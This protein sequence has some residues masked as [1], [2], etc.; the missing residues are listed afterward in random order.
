LT[1]L[2]A[3]RYSLPFMETN[4]EHGSVRLAR[5]LLLVQLVVSPII[6]S[7]TTLEAFE[8]NKVGLLVLT[9]LLLATGTV[10]A[11]LGPT[12]RSRLAAAWHDVRRCPLSLSVIAF[13]LSTMLSTVAS[14]SPR[15]SVFGAH[16]SFSGLVMISAYAILFFA[17]RALFR[18]ANAA[19]WLLAAPV[20]GAAFSGGY[21]ALQ[22]AHLDPIH[23]AGVSP[24]AG[25]VRP[26][27]GLG[28]P[29]QLAAY[30]A[31]VLPLVV[32]FAWRAVQGRQSRALT[33]IVGIGALMAFAVL[34]AVSRG[35]WL[36]LIGAGA[37]TL[38]PWLHGRRL[39][40]K[41]GV[42]LLAI[43]GVVAW[44]TFT[45]TGQ[46]LFNSVVERG[47]HFGD[48]S[49]RAQIWRA[50]LG[51][52]WEHPV[53][54]CGLDTFNL[55]FQAQRTPK[56][57]H[58]EWNGTPTKAHSDALQVLATQGLV[59]IA[60][61]VAFTVALLRAGR[62]AW[63]SAT[64]QT[65]PLIA[66][67][68]G[69]C[70]AL[71]LQ[72]LFS[73]TTAATGVV[74]VTV[75]ALLSRLAEEDTREAAEGCPA[76]ALPAGSGLALLLFANEA[77]VYSGI[78]AARVL[79]GVG[80]LCIGLFAACWALTSLTHGTPEQRPAPAPGPGSRFRLAAQAGVWTA[81]LTA[82]VFLVVLPDLASRYVRRSDEW[83]AA[84]PGRAVEEL[85][86]ALDLDPGRD[87][88]WS[89]L[90]TAYQAK[91]VR[92]SND[93]L[94]FED[95]RRARAALD[96]A[97][98]L[99]PIQGYHYANR[100]RL[101]AEMVPLH[102]ATTD[103]TFADFDRALQFDGANA[104]FYLYAGHVART[105]GDRDHAHCYIGR[106]LQLYPRFGPLRTQD[107]FLA[108]SEGR[109][110]DAEAMYPE[111]PYLDW[112][113]DGRAYLNLLAVM[114]WGRL[115]HDCYLDA[116]V[117]SRHVLQHLPK[118]GLPRFTVAQALEGLG[119]KAEALEEYRQL[120]LV[121]PDYAPARDAR[122]RLEREL[123]VSAN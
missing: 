15:T 13:W 54:G 38:W 56:Y 107:A 3:R 48:A 85:G 9:S 55:A 45:T 93:E 70:A 4:R 112:H 99:V 83:L 28:H 52:W 113:D 121:C 119:R 57:W 98:A 61:A 104:Y 74:F 11:C 68:L 96:C 109:S 26:F 47:R 59:G 16:E 120:L 14:C 86:K 36:A 62:R 84:D 49:S 65:R 66:A 5:A 87:L 33:V 41:A 35:A 50:A 118:W 80:A 117:V 20:V 40:V 106:G 95:L 51:I 100:G 116:L 122:C 1:G 114:A 69:V 21:A 82:I 10:A 78:P 30:L 32:Y 110:D 25:Y 94:Q 23:W 89:R 8:C 2:A 79:V 60:A 18:S 91:A 42:A 24:L 44:V 76:W 43:I 22:V 64:A 105:L 81:G 72:G 111:A 77:I 123:A 97:V 115:Q 101:L 27:A 73:F 108:M 12:A 39:A 92:E 102:L 63:R 88:Y 67:L 75:A 31:M 6:F 7:L 103:E 46:G 29:N 90:A 53:L 37:I 19:V 17:T 34:A 58:V 71:Y